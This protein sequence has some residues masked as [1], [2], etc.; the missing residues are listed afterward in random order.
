MR[1]D[2]LPVG[3][4][5]PHRAEAFGCLL[6]GQYQANFGRNAGGRYKG[7]H[8]LHVLKRAHDGAAHGNL[9]AVG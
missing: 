2:R 7:H 6:H 9:F 4:T 8:V 3:A 5:F 1:E